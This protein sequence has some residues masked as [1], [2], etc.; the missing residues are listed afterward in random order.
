MISRMAT[1]RVAKAAK[2][3]NSPSPPARLRTCR[4]MWITMVQSTSES[5]GGGG[6]TQ[7]QLSLAKGKGCEPRSWLFQHFCGK[8]PEPCIPACFGQDHYK[9]LA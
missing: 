1:V 6:G 8:C 5:S 3:K 7:V 2:M 9:Q 4:P